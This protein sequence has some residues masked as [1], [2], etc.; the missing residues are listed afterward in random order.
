MQYRAPSRREI[1]HK[2][3]VNFRRTD[4]K[5]KNCTTCKRC[6]CNIVKSQIDNKN[7]KHYTCYAITEE[8]AI[9]EKTIYMSGLSFSVL[10]NNVCNKHGTKKT[11]TKKTSSKKLK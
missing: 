7:H 1:E 10:K 8:E 3:K 5:N 4:N 9:K 2:D 6:L 11:S